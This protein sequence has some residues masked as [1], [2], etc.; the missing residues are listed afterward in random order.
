MLLLFSFLLMNSVVGRAVSTVLTSL[1]SVFSKHSVSVQACWSTRLD[2]TTSPA[3]FCMGRARSGGKSMGVQVSA[4]HPAK[5]CNKGWQRS[6]GEQSWRRVVILGKRSIPSQRMAWR[7]VRISPGSH[8]E[9]VL[10]PDNV[11]GESLLNRPEKH[12]RYSRYNMP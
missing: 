12:K 1:I 6:R 2:F 7:E 10:R 9:G 4:V 11:L 8:Q 5:R 3:G